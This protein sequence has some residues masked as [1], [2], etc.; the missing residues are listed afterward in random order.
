MV[1]DERD[2]VWCVPESRMHPFPACDAGLS[3]GPDESWRVEA[4]DAAWGGRG[5]SVSYA[6]WLAEGRDDV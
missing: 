2:V 4:D 6:E 1:M 5:P 3:L